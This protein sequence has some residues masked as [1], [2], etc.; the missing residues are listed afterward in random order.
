[1]F[2]FS[3]HI[4]F[5]CID[6]TLIKLFFYKIPQKL[7][8]FLNFIVRISGWCYNSIVENSFKKIFIRQ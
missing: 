6:C 1:M 2:N 8:R 7:I 3:K 5:F 4:D